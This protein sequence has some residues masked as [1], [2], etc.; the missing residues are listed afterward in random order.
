LLDWDEAGLATYR[1]GSI[2]TQVRAVRQHADKRS[3]K[4][5]IGLEPSAPGS[6]QLVSAA[7]GIPA[8][9]QQSV[10]LT[11]PQHVVEDRIPG[12]L[13]AQQADLLGASA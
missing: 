5:T 12:G 11:A 3:A 4:A 1:G 2:G 9:A 10:P 13:L 7:G 6:G 8:A